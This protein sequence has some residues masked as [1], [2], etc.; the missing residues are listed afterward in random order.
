M[1]LPDANTPEDARLAARLVVEALVPEATMRAVISKQRE[2]IERGKPLSVGEICLR[3]QWVTRS[4]MLLLLS[5]DRPF[6]ELLPRLRLKGLVGQG[7]M[8]RVYE[9]DGPAGPVAVKI[10]HPRLTRI[11]T[12]VDSFRKEAELLTSLRHENIVRGYGLF[13]HD[14]LVFFLMELVQG[15]SIQQQ[16]DAG[17]RFHEDEALSIILQVARALSHLHAM[18]LVHR[19]VKPA[20]M[21]IDTVGTVKLCDLG[22]AISAGTGAGESTAG[23]AQYIAPEQATAETGLDVRSDIY[24]LGVSLYQLILGKLPFEGETNQETIARR[25]LDELRSKDL[26][27]IGISPLVHYFIQKMM[28]MEREVRYQDPEELIED[29]ESQI[30]GSRSMAAPGDRRV[31]PGTGSPS[32]VH[33]N[34]QRPITVGVGLRRRRR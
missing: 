25:L 4:E 31:A 13:E 34:L 16:L 1:Q 21:L 9:A 32:G 20:N 30:Q 24:A 6:S 18:G 5:P 3:K 33:P 26:K 11:P 19:D 22:L 2:L 12:E 15:Q 14:G 17:R 23:T 29:V 7:G 10:L 28:A 27:S 8:S